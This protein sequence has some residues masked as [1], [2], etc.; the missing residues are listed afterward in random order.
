MR[1]C[2]F[3]ATG[4]HAWNTGSKLNRV[5]YHAP[6]SH[7]S[8]A[9]E[10]V[11]G[12]EGGAGKEATAEAEAAEAAEA[13]PKNAT[14]D[15]SGLREWTRERRECRSPNA[16]DPIRAASDVSVVVDPTLKPSPPPPPPNLSIAFPSS[17]SSSDSERLLLLARTGTWAY[18]FGSVTLASAGTQTHWCARGH[19][20]THTPTSP[21]SS[22]PRWSAC[23]CQ[24]YGFPATPSSTPQSRPR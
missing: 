16:S 9:A 2:A 10:G 7:A 21:P 18:A 4:R 23:G 5:W 8:V 17:S 19:L 20:R 14:R 1:F 11:G 12:G 3:A 22:T 24:R 13:A 6:P 15:A